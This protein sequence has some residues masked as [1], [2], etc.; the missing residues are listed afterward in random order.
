MV[1][2]SMAAGQIYQGKNWTKEYQLLY[3]NKV[4]DNAIM[5][6]KYKKLLDK[7]YLEISKQGLN[8]VLNKKYLRKLYDEYTR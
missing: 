6:P 7:V 3:W 5:H 4:K 2:D 8:A 1:C